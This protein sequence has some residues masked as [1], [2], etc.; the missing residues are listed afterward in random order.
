MRRTPRPAPARRAHVRVE[1]LEDRA[2]PTLTTPLPPRAFL[3]FHDEGLRSLIRERT[4]QINRLRWHLHDVDSGLEL[5]LG[6]PRGP[7]A[8]GELI[9][10]GHAVAVLDGL[11][12]ERHEER[13]RVA[14]RLR[15]ENFLQ[16]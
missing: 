7:V 3:R 15:A 4:A 11:W 1:S 14:P 2:L 8:W 13:Y 6:H 5:G 12:T 10:T 16:A 9:G